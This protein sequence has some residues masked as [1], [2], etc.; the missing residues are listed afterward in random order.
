VIGTVLSGY[1]PGEDLIG[2]ETGRVLEKCEKKIGE[3][4][5]TSHQDVYISE[6]SIK[7]GTGFK[8]GDVVRSEK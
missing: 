4:A 5:I 1:R 7:S 6:A 2:P 3:I 8:A